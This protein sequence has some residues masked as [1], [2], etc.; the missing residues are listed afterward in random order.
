[1]NRENPVVLEDIRHICSD[2]NISRIFCDRENK[3]SPTQ[4]ASGAFWYME[5][6]LE[7]V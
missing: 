1:M 4:T 7:V 6:L 2:T 3:I 5:G